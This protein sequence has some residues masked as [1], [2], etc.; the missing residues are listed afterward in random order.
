[1][2]RLAKKQ[3]TL[4]TALILLRPDGVV[5]AALGGA[6]S[7]WLGRSLVEGRD[8]PKE[9]RAAASALLETPPIASSFARWCEVTTDRG[10]IELVVLEAL[11]L[12][13]AHVRVSD[14]LARTLDAFVTQART[15]S[16]DLTVQR[17]PQVPDTVFVDA[18][19]VAWA[20][21]TVV[22]NALR[23]AREGGSRT[24]HVHVRVTLDARHDELVVSVTDN[25]PGI[26]EE[27]AR[28]LFERNPATGRASG[29]ALVMV[30][31]VLVAHRGA[32]SVVSKLGHGTTIRLTLPR[33]AP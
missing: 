12:R 32:A 26:S 28:W 15:S 17:S 7:E 22:G 10:R 24:P 16:I 2:P 4:G 3:P 33:L 5:D 19:K 31:D 6:P 8:V 27:R 18:E 9:V 11:P 23:F 29:L 25:G 20:L 13:R 1:M 30:R 14:L 21:A